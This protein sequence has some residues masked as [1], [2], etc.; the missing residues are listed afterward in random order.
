MKLGFPTLLVAISTS[1]IVHLIGWALLVESTIQEINYHQST[2]TLIITPNLTPRSEAIINTKTPLS[3]LTESQPPTFANER[4]MFTEEVQLV[5]PE[6]RVSS[7]PT[8]MEN[9]TSTQPI[10]EISISQFSPQQVQP[11]RGPGSIVSA[12]NLQKLLSLTVNQQLTQADRFQ[13]EPKVSTIPIQSDFP[14]E[15]LSIQPNSLP[16]NLRN[17]TTST[18][19]RIVQSTLSISSSLLNTAQPTLRQR[20]ESAANYKSANLVNQPPIY[21]TSARQQ[22]IEGR[23]ILHVVVTSNGLPKEIAIFESS[24]ASMLDKAAIVA[25]AEWQFVPATVK[26]KTVESRLLIPIRFHLED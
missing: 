11:I 23:V 8:S 2:V 22:G 24:G 9:P 6:L 10:N 14:R 26:S 12:K 4:E 13:P 7:P 21:P 16:P 25:V 1:V 18:G 20:N 15:P 5:V 17:H 3:R 19:A